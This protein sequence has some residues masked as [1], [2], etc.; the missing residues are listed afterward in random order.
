M[1]KRVSVLRDVVCAILPLSGEDRVQIGFGVFTH[2]GEGVQV[3]LRVPGAGNA[4][5]GVSSGTGGR[6]LP[7]PDPSAGTLEA[8]ADEGE[9]VWHH[10]S[11]PESPEELGS[12]IRNVREIPIDGAHMGDS[13]IQRDQM[14]VGVPWRTKVLVGL[15]NAML[16]N[17]LHGKR[18]GVREETYAK[19]ERG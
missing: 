17:L 3:Q 12:Y 10:F 13:R 6:A 5:R 14:V 9:G 11:R 16:S 4:K 1:K 8:V 7:L 2:S 18:L 15:A 19:K